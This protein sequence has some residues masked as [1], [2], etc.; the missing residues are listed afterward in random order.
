MN[1]ITHLVF[2]AVCT[3]VLAG[4][5]YVSTNG[6]HSVA[7]SDDLWG[8]YVTSNDGIAHDAYTNLQQAVTAA[9]ANDTIWVENGFVWD[10]GVVSTSVGDTR[11]NVTKALTIR[12]R[13][14]S[15]ENGPVIRGA[16]AVDCDGTDATKCGAGA[17][18]CVVFGS[19]YDAKLIGFRLENGAT[20]A[21]SG[22]AARGGGVNGKGILENCLILTDFHPEPALQEML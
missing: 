2:F 18:R 9:A 16:Y 15:W 19:N 12:G 20:A 4:D 10:S 5:L 7:D 8:T 6:I 22:N 13:S 1:T 21:G 11:L 17:A 3:S 14:G